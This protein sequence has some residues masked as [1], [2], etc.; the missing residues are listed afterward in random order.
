VATIGALSLPVVVGALGL[1]VDLNRG[2]EQ[3]LFNQRA[4]DMAALGA[5]MA[6]KQSTNVDTLSP[7]ATDIANANG[8]RGAT[9]QTSI[10]ENYPSSGDRAVRVIVT[11]P[12]EYTLARVV[13]LKGT[14][15]VRAESY[16][17]LTSQA[18]YSAPCFLA[19]DTGAGA[20]TVTGGAS[21]NAPT[22]SVAAV[23][24]IAQNGS[25]ITASDIISGSGSVSVG[26]GS[27]VANTLRYA[28]SFIVAGTNMATGTSWNTAIPPAN[29]RVN[30][31][32]TLADPWADDATLVSARGQL[33]TYTT[34]PTLSNPTTA[35]ASAK[36]WDFS[37]S[38]ASHISAWWNSTAK[39]YTVPTGTYYINKVSVAGDITVK[40]GDGSKIYINGG[41]TN[42]GKAFNF[43]NSDVYVNG[44]FNSGSS[45]VTF[46]NGI[47]WIGNGA[48]GATC[49]W[50]PYTTSVCFNGTNTKGTG[51]VQINA[52]TVLGGGSKF[53]MGAGNHYFG[54]L[55]LGGGGSISLGAG[56][57]VSTQGVKIAGGSEL[58]MGA[59]DVIIGPASDG[60]AIKIGGSSGMFMEDGTFSANGH[61]D[62]DGGSRLIFGKTTNHYIN[63]NM[64]IRGGVL[65]GAGRYTINGNFING[66]GGAQWPWTSSFTSKTYG[67]SIEGVSA[68]GYDMVG[69]DVTFILKG[70]LNLGGGAKTKL[71][72][73][74]ASVSGG[75]IAE[76]L[77]HSTTTTATTWGAGAQNIFV[78]SVHVPNSAVTMSGGNTTLSSGQCFTLIA[79]KISVTGGAATGSACPR[80]SGSASGSSSTDIKLIR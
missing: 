79:S 44:G 42:G 78:G 52:M 12:I 75:Q 63:G 41:F 39:T 3:R 33:G 48:G 66:T 19:L 77:L 57:F 58:A 7:T 56:N 55:D 2:Y 46:G 54:G 31:A 15:T 70:T 20:I 28:G 69:V 9:I 17:T 38:P 34:P 37:Y 68:V 47:L 62:T 73:P 26:S 36:D 8:L 40:F 23:G 65:F 30:D 45:G 50:Y 14:Y 13:G 21:I 11:R 80:M 51:D 29:K 27:L 43:G 35:N 60:N 59:G 71:Y 61:I 53:T 49:S 5:A 10:V 4:A 72:A 16:A 18:A 24:S 1:A 6:Y 64:N 67:Q 74:T 25:T 32:T 22:C 76:M